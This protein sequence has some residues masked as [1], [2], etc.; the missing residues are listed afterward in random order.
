M[1]SVERSLGR[2]R[3]EK[4]EPRPID[5]DLLLYDNDVIN[6][7]SLAVPHPLMHQRRFVLEPLAE[8]AADVVHPLFQK[9]IS[10]LLAG[11]R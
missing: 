10:T 2:Q 8:I 7:D 1:L 5:L 6:T 11:L 4:W 3:R 9:N